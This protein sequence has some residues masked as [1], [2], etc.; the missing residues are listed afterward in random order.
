MP[1]G[2]ALAWLKRW[3]LIA[4]AAT[5]IQIFIGAVMRH[6]D[7]GL[8]I[9]RFPLANEHSL[10]PAY[11]NFPVAI[12]FAHRVGAVFL[13]GLLLWLCVHLWRFRGLD[14]LFALFSSVIVGILSLQI[15]LGALTIWTAKNPYSATMHHLVGAFLLASVWG[16]AFILNRNPESE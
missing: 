5:F 12:H 9:A 1:E 10:I 8:A 6:A 15:Y 7:A 13:T 2:T 3:A 11:W 14:R 4:Y 16:I